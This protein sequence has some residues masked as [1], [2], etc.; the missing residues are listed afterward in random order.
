MQRFL[1]AAAAATTAAQ[2]AQLPTAHAQSAAYPFCAVYA[3][4]GGTPNCYFATR[5]QC[6][7]DVSGVGGLCVE[8]RS[9]RPVTTGA[10]PRRQSAGGRAHARRAS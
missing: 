7:A 5:E 10:A 3:S 4:K 1:L 9:Y 2:F 6:M 8:N